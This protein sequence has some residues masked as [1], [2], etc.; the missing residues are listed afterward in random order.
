MPAAVVFVGV[1]CREK[2]EVM[3]G[4]MRKASRILVM[5]WGW[6]SE[7]ELE[8]VFVCRVETFSKHRGRASGPLPGQRP[9][10]GSAGAWWHQA[11]AALKRA[12]LTSRLCPA[13]QRRLGGHR[14]QGTWHL[15]GPPG[16]DS[17]FFTEAAGSQ[18]A[19]VSFLLKQEPS[20]VGSMR[21]NM[22]KKKYLTCMEKAL[23]THS[24]ILA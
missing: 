16:A 4:L 23:A 19:Q 12:F 13:C 11:S 6:H 21:F 5:G 2:T 15:E 14:E 9:S 18:W 20:F 1:A 24:S 8:K 3:W 7:A 22:Q 10:S 17:T